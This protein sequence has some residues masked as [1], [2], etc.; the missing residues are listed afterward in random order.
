[1]SPLSQLSALS[2]PIPAEAQREVGTRGPR[3]QT[4][5]PLSKHLQPREAGILLRPTVTFRS[6]AHASYTKVCFQCKGWGGTLCL[7][8][9]R[10]PE[11]EP[12]P[13]E[14]LLSLPKDPHTGPP[15]RHITLQDPAASGPPSGCLELS[16]A[17]QTREAMAEGTLS[18]GCSFTHNP[19]GLGRFCCPGIPSPQNLP[20]L[21]GP[22]FH[23]LPR[24]VVLIAP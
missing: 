2:H 22:R 24:E 18:V 8:T 19:P 4:S 16:H 17:R 7:I 5:T 9:H 6:Q 3:P 10:A 1:M 20:C 12:Y 23:S 14:H 13:C 15:S 11:A 21:E